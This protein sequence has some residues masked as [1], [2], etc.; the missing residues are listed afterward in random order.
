MRPT[1]KCKR[2]RKRKRAKIPSNNF[3]PKR[4]S[5]PSV[6]CSN[7]PHP[8]SKFS[9]L[10]TK[11]KSMKKVDEVDEMDIIFGGMLAIKAN[12][13]RKGHFGSFKRLM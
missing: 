5:S 12:G 13:K 9:L 10:C 8:L 6:H 7:T 4:E 3:G 11:F 2:K 1:S